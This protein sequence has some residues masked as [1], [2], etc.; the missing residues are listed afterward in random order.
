MPLI[1]IFCQFLPNKKYPIIYVTSIFPKATLCLPRFF[2]FLFQLC[3]P[4]VALFS[5]PCFHCR[6]PSGLQCPLSLFS[7]AVPCL[8]TLSTNRK[9]LKW[10]VETED[11]LKVWGGAKSF[12]EEITDPRQHCLWIYFRLDFVQPIAKCNFEPIIR[13]GF[14]LRVQSSPYRFFGASQH[15][16]FMSYIVVSYIAIYTWLSRQELYSHLYMYLW[17]CNTYVV[18]SIFNVASTYDLANTYDVASTYNVASIYDAAS[19]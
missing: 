19:T 16:L 2:R 14:V 5:V 4:L 9:V 17:C 13:R 15:K 10:T 12:K 1:V 3:S 7:H 11:Q 6:H 18:A 8:V